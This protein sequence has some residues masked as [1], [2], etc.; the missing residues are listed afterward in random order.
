[1]P[2]TIESLREENARLKS[3]MC[4]VLTLLEQVARS[5][6]MAVEGA[7]AIS[8]R[9]REQFKL[10][11]TSISQK[12]MRDFFAKSEALVNGISDEMLDRVVEDPDLPSFEGE[13]DGDDG[14]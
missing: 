4:F 2:E 7:G 10:K 13:G 3:G 9:I 8:E 6:S 14:E 5:L 12:A 1:M 11:N